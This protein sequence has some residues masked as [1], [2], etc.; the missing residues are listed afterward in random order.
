MIFGLSRLGLARNLRRA[1]DAAILK[2][3]VEVQFETAKENMA[4]VAGLTRDGDERRLE[5]GYS[6]L[7]LAL[8]ELLAAQRR[9]PA[10]D[11]VA[12]DDLPRLGTIQHAL[13]PALREWKQTLRQMNR[14]S[15]AT[16]V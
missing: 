14:R 6:R 3:R 16:T 10:R 12:A 13:E 4:R 5:D 11:A 7:Q 2:A 8:H 15:A 9:P 1:S